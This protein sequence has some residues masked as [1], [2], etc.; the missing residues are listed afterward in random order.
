MKKK[1]ALVL[2]GGSARGI[3]HIGVIEE[4]LERR[5]EITSVA[6]TSM[7]ALVGGVY[8]LGKLPEFKEWLFTLDRM[9][10]FSLVDFTLSKHGIIKGD[11]V[12]SKMKEFI[13]DRN[14]ED[15]T[16]PYAAV[17]VDIH[18]NSEV[19]FRKGSIYKAIRASI[20][21]PTILT[22]V[23]DGDRLLVD[24]GVLNNIPVN[25]AQRVRRD[26]LVAVNVNADIEPRQLPDDR[27]DADG[28]SENEKLYQKK[29]K[30]F[31][32]Y[33][34]KMLPDRDDDGEDELSYFDLVSETIHSM[35]NHIAKL[36]LETYPPDLVINISHDICKTYDFYKAMELVEAGRYAAREA[37]DSL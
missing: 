26:L 7:G 14:I 8:A 36:N 11:K 4:L 19:V 28:N 33:L 24:G 12:L 15:L 25:H 30:E 20:A 16:I 18:T 10:V 23:E 5:Y 31:N 22:P 17:A 2:S 34:K 1:I 37:L 21:I 9:K 29:I 35:I 3:A 27:K 13:P 32:S 6:G